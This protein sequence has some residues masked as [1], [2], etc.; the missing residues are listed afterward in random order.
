MPIATPIPT[1]TPAA[2]TSWTSPSHRDPPISGSSKL[3]SI[4]SPATSTIVVSGRTEAPKISACSQPRQRRWKSLRC[5]RTSILAGHPARN[6]APALD[7][8]AEADEPCEQ[9]CPSRP[10]AR[11]R[12]RYDCE[13][14]GSSDH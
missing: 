3:G 8:P 11:R 5:P 1:S 6:V 12:H 13:D 2:N 10:R 7:R 14:R 4:S 9:P